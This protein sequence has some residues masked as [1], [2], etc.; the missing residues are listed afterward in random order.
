MYAT[1]AHSSASDHTIPRVGDGRLAGTV[2][3]RAISG[4]PQSKRTSQLLA[5]SF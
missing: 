5:R 3:K 2:A 1:P 4:G